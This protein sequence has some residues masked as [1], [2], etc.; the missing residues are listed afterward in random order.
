MNDIALSIDENNNK[1]T[2]GLLVVGGVICV[3][4]PVT[5]I[6]VIGSSLMPNIIGDVVSKTVKNFA[7]NLNNNALLSNDKKSDSFAKKNINKCKP[8]IVFNTILSK[9]EKAINDPSFEPNTELNDSGELILLT[10][11]LLKELFPLKENGLFFSKKPLP[12]NVERYFHVL[13]A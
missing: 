11:P 7:D 10:Y 6:A 13:G 12:E 5:G 8:E 3:A 4:N 1:I 2:N 9:L